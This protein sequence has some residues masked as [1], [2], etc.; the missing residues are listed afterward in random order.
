MSQQLMHNCSG[1]SEPWLRKP[2]SRKRTVII[3]CL[4]ALAVFA[5][6]G[7]TIRHQF[8]NFDDD[9]CVYD[10][11]VV[12][13]GLSLDGVRWAFTH[14]QAGIWQPLTTLS[15]MLDCQ[16]YGLHAGGHH[17]TNVILHT[18]AAVL[19]FLAF[20]RM[21]NATWLSAFVA[22]L[23]AIH[24]LRVE[25]VAWIAERKDVLSGLLFVLTLWAYGGYAARPSWPR[26]AFVYVS[27]ALGL[28]AKP[29][30]VTLPFVLLLLDYWPLNR[31]PRV[32]FQ[33]SGGTATPGGNYGPSAAVRQTSLSAL[34]AEKIPLL[35]LACASAAV[36]FHTQ[37]EAGAIKPVT[38]L[39]LPW[40]L[41]NAAVSYSIYIVQMIFPHALAPYYPLRVKG[42]P[43]PEIVAAVVALLLI[44]GAVICLRRRFPYLAVGWFW[45]LGMLVPVI[46]LVQVGDAGHADRYTYLPQIGLYLLVVWG[47]ADLCRTHG[48]SRSLLRITAV[49]AFVALFVAASVQTAHWR[50]SISLWSHTLTCTSAN[51]LAHY[52]LGHALEAD[53]RPG[54]AIQQFERVLQLAPDYADAYSDMGVASA[55]LGQ[56]EKSV[57]YLERALQIEPNNAQARYNLGNALITQGKLNEGLWY[58][59]RA[60]PLLP[61]NADAHNNVGL[62]WARLGQWDKAVEHYERALRIEPGDANTHCY[63]GNALFAQGKLR[64]ASQQYE[65]ARRLDPEYPDAWNNL[66]VVLAAEGKLPDALE[67]FEQALKLNPDYADAHRN[68]G[69]ALSAQGRWNDALRHLE[70]TIQ[71]RPD[72]AEGHYQLGKVL[73]SQEKT[74]EAA[75]H[76][77][78]ALR[79]AETQDNRAL[80][81]AVRLQ[82]QTSPP[83]LTQP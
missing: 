64:E 59:E 30:L 57:Q 29:M 9:V 40:R 46:G 61:D 4:L 71:L 23:F 48:W 25:S 50:D 5:V 51:P 75:R 76:F 58:C 2:D 45:Y 65:Q 1:D 10:N 20:Q 62:A 36:T 42:L 68:L 21:T 22:A 38:D 32:N 73:A 44:T 17:F 60:L 78:L 34:I 47:A 31:W 77:Q 81:E 11:A 82:L 80:A 74:N 66:G 33:V 43:L 26:Y 27:F 67:H 8:I 53:G 72:D 79:L 3:S 19:L 69:K 18:V 35:V 13:R 6:F 41:A 54:E 15:H 28:L 37:S 70:R 14:S 83:V 55:K 52:N 49:A 56:S 24:P 7:Q 12:T 63:L 39:A 16:L